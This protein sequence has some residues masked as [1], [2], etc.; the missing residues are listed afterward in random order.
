ML[1]ILKWM[2]G[3]SGK[4]GSR[5]VVLNSWILHGEIW[6]GKQQAEG[7][8]GPWMIF[9]HYLMVRTWS[10]NFISSAAKIDRTTVWVR[11]M[12]LNVVFSGESF[13]LSVASTLGTPI[14]IDMN[15]LNVVRGRFTRI[16]IEISLNQ[17]VVDI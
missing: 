13:H 16:C 9:Y 7:S 14:K 10:S 8:E 17:P 12:D 4:C 6:S 5:L 1:A 15:S 11:I 2:F 3:W